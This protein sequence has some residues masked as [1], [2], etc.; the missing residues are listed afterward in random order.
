MKAKKTSK[1]PTHKQPPH[2][3]YLTPSGLALVAAAHNNIDT[4]FLGNTKNLGK[5]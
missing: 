3:V 2:T 5:K 4:A 1:P